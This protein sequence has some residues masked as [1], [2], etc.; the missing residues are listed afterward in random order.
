M[1]FY[2]GDEAGLVKAVHFVAPKAEAKPVSTKGKPKHDKLDKDNDQ[3]EQRPVVQA[4][5]SVDKIM[6]I[7]MMA[8][9]SDKQIVVARNSGQIQYISTQT[10]SVVREYMH[11]HHPADATNVGISPSLSKLEHFVGLHE[12]EGTL[13]S[14]TSHGRVIYDRI[15]ESETALP[16][17]AVSLGQDQLCRMRV[18]ASQPNIFVTGGKEREIAI[19]DINRAKESAL[20]PIWKS[21]N[22]KN[23]FLDLRVPVWNTDIQWCTPSDTTKFV[24]GTGHH[25]IRLYDTKAARRPVISKEVGEHPVRALALAENGQEVILSDTTD[26]MMSFDLRMQKVV[27]RYKGLDGCVTSNY[28]CGNEKSVVSVSMDRHLRV[29][30]RTSKANLLKKVYLTQ[31][32]SAV[33]VDEEW[34]D[35]SST[36][37]S[38]RDTQIGEGLSHRAKAAAVGDDGD[39]EDEDIWERMKQ[40]DEENEYDAEAPRPKKRKLLEKKVKRKTAF[41]VADK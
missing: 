28:A 12:T 36:T 31:R 9:A 25:Q 4:W 39:D 17:L 2:T 22:V 16:S 24:V 14:C 41:I 8:W 27:A 37:K 3:P 23:D 30:A 38:T 34:V 32:L 6:G 13:I 20:Q 35:E 29:H 1:R 15:S 19:W 7:Q 40:V 26:L 21:K 10:G 18:S 5:G 11:I 33:L